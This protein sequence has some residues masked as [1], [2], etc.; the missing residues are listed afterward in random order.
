M[1]TGGSGKVMKECMLT[2]FGGYHKLKVVDAPKPGSPG[3][4]QVL[5][6]VVASG[7]NFA[8]LHAR[9]GMYKSKDG[10]VTPPC[11]LGMEASGTV[12][13]VGKGVE[14]LQVGDRVFCINMFELWKE[15]VVIP[16]NR[17]FVM[18]D[19]MSFE[20]AASIPVNYLTAYLMLFDFGNLRKNKSVL[21]HMAAGGVGFAVTQLCKTVENVT[22]FGTSS[23]H[24]HKA[25]QA[26]GV[27]HPIDYRTKDYVEE[28]RKISPNGV[29]IVLDPLCGADTKK[30]YDLLKPMGKLIIFGAANGMTGEHKSFTN[31]ASMWWSLPTFKPLSMMTSN[32]SV[33]GFHLGYLSGDDESEAMITDAAADLVRMYKEGLIKPHVDSVWPF[34]KAGDAMKYIAD[35]KNVGKVVLSWEK[36]DDT[37]EK[38][39]GGGEKKDEGNEKPGVL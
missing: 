28:V 6:K 20:E 35:R 9:Q 8:E 13:E 37:E 30:G 12:E 33:A 34:E 22:V 4:G 21:C 1:A 19:E 31:L 2:G 5:I 23:E 18:P 38:K 11:V 14:T 27:D 32:K 39:E 16:A 36:K 29:D 7:I 17:A 25:I 24:K 3:D 26:N 10:K 15:Y